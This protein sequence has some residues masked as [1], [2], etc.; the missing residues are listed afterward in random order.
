[1]IFN[2]RIGDSDGT[3]TVCVNISKA[4]EKLNDQFQWHAA[5]LF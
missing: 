5:I 1:M 3:C 2:I 4:L